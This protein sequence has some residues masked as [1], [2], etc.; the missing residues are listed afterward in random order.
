M[1][2]GK[3]NP[4]ECEWHRDNIDKIMNDLYGNSGEGIMVRFAR[5]ET[6]AKLMLAIELLLLS[7]VVA[8]VFKTFIG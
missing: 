3:F 7:G 6:K 8:L 2:N 1:T 4:K 5:L